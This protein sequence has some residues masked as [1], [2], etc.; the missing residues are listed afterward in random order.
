MR[1]GLAGPLPNY[2]LQLVGLLLQLMYPLRL[3]G[4]IA[5][6]FGDLAF[7]NVRQF[8]WLRLPSSA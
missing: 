5:A 4:E 1:P 2:S 7:D 6:E 3:H 8:G